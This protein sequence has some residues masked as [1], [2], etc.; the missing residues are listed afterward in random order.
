M[1]TPHEIRD[2][3]GAKE[4]KVK[5]GVITFRNVFFR[6]GKARLVLDGFNLTVKSKEKVALVGPSGAGKS[7]VVKLILRFHDI[8]KGKIIDN[9]D[10]KKSPRI[11]CATPSPWCR[12]IRFCF[13]AV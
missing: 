2:R 11:L 10:I 7:T 5:K 13:T 8:Q 12:K 3:R 1:H 6:Y 9:Q 4:I